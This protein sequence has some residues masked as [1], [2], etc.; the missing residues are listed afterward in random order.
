MKNT[1]QEL[2]L[3]A[4]AP[5]RAD[6]AADELWV[7]YPDVGGVVGVPLTRSKVLKLGCYCQDFFTPLDRD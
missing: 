6:E 1:N 5:E 7:L 3:E 2:A 4:I